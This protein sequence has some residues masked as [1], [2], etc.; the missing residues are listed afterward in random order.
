MQLSST[1]RWSNT[2]GSRCWVI[3]AIDMTCQARCREVSFHITLDGKQYLWWTIF[4]C[5]LCDNDNCRP[6]SKEGKLDTD[7]TREENC[8]RKVSDGILET[9]HVAI[10]LYSYL[11]LCLYLSLYLYFCL[12]L[13]LCLGNLHL[14]NDEIE[15]VPASVG[16]QTRVEWECNQGG[17]LRL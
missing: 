13:C 3:K 17:V 6:A 1:R 2:P 14:L 11:C 12:F 4:V 8:T 7:H 9:L 16:K 5:T 10:H 15:V